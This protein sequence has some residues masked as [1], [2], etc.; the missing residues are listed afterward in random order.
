MLPIL[1]LVS[2]LP[3]ALPWRGKSEALLL[4]PAD[5]W[6]TPFEASG[7]LRT[8]SYD[9][10]VGFLRRLAEQS[11]ELRLVSLGRSGEGRELWMAIAARGGAATP[12][13]VRRLG[14]PVLMVQAG[15]HAGEI[16]GKDAGLML[17]RDVVA[18]RTK[19][20]LLD[21]ASLLFVPI[22]NVDGHERV[23]ATSRINQRGPA[24]TG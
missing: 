3:P 13:A 20:A 11:P 6:A 12:E 1:L 10:T 2:I 22:F 9:Q 18:S 15:I 14:K 8:P 23:S 17:L 7:G 19:A 24:E 5:P 16:D 21:V 4:P